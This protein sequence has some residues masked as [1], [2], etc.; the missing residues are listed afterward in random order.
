MEYMNLYRIG[1]DLQKYIIL[2]LS[3]F[4][5]FNGICCEL[6]KKQY[7]YKRGDTRYKI[8]RTH[9][10]FET[11]LKKNPEIKCEKKEAVYISEKYQEIDKSQIKYLSVNEVSKYLTEMKNT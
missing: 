4:T 8:F 10:E 1:I 6:I 3:V 7:T 5:A 11:F 9:S 2:F